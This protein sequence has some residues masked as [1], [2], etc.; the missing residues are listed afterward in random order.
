MYDYSVIYEKHKNFL[1]D[2]MFWLHVILIFLSLEM[3]TDFQIAEITQN[4]V[5]EQNTSL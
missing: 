5:F 3:K 1:M 4:F 2:L